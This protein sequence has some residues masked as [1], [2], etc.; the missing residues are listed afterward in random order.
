MTQVQQTILALA[1]NA[2]SEEGACNLNALELAMHLT[3]HVGM[4][5]LE[6]LG[7]VT[8]A[9]LMS[10]LTLLDIYRIVAGISGNGK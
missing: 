6:E 2:L 8:L 10:Q 4:K 3:R 9:D 7:K 5:E 1:V